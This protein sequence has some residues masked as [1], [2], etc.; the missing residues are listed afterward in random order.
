MEIKKLE[1]FPPNENPFNH[2]TYHMGVRIGSN[3]MAMMSKFT[4]EEQSYIILVNIKTGERIRI[5]FQS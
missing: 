4:D 5:D 1:S 2:D 3:V